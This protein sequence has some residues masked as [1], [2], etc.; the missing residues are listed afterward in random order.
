[1]RRGEDGK[2]EGVELER[3][4][5]GDIFGLFCWMDGWM[6]VLGKLRRAEW[7]S[8]NRGGGKSFPKLVRVDVAK[9][10]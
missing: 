5:W 7:C 3:G 4:V 6:S 2:G 1:M 9:N 10:K 8:G